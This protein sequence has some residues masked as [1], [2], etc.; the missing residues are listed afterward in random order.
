MFLC[1]ASDAAATERKRM[2]R[3]GPNTAEVAAYLA[4]LPTLSST[5]WVAVA[6]TA[7]E[8]RR[9]P[10]EWSA[11]S[12]ALRAAEY[13]PVRAAAKRA[14][15]I[16]VPIAGPEWPVGAAWGPEPPSD[17]ARDAQQAR[18]VE[19]A[20][21]W[22]QS[23]SPVWAPAFAAV[24]TA[25]LKAVLAARLAGA[26][27]GPVHGEVSLDVLMAAKALTVRA[28]ITDRHFALLTASMCAAG[29]EFDALLIPS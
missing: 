9:G 28:I 8:T 5:Q 3:F 10:G 18:T 15:S 20:T 21:A 23:W 17:P 4:L 6:A 7:R 22:A 12:S 26:M 1:Q 25:G 27:P 29:I 13:D 16:A 14:A 19:Q 24:K 11:A 2:D